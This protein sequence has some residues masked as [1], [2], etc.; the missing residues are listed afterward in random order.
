MILRLNPN[1]L[2]RYLIPSIVSSRHRIET[3]TT[4]TIT[5]NTVLVVVVKRATVM[6]VPTTR[7]IIALAV[8]RRAT[9]TITPILVIQA[10]GRN[11]VTATA[12]PPA[13]TRTVAT[14]TTREEPL[15][16]ETINILR[17]VSMDTRLP[18]SIVLIMV[19]VTTERISS[20]VTVNLIL[21]RGREVPRIWRTVAMIMC[22]VGPRKT[23]NY[24][25]KSRLL[26]TTVESVRMTP[27]KS[28]FI[29]FVAARATPTS[30]N[31]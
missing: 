12:T 13:V 10:A 22:I 5:R 1:G 29:G 25:A 2:P 15:A 8:E 18:L 28:S 24:N 23:M 19:T 20:A 30:N 7:A 17:P 9:A 16:A 3:S 26:T 4:T 11:T 6:I 14:S 27:W 31:A 21:L